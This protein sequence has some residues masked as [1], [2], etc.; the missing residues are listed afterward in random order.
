M[1]A[2]QLAGMEIEVER[3]PSHSTLED[4]VNR[5]GRGMR[6]AS[7]TGLGRSSLRAAALA[8]LRLELTPVERLRYRE[9]GR[10]VSHAVEATARNFELPATEAEVAGQ[11]VHRLY[12]RM[13]VP[14]EVYVASEERL[15]GFPRPIPGLCAGTGRMV[16]FVK[17]DGEFAEDFGHCSMVQGAA[18]YYS[19]PGV[20]S[21]EL[22]AKVERTFNRLGREDQVRRVSPGAVTGYS[23]CE[24]PLLPDGRYQLGDSVAVSWQPCVGMVPGCDTVLID[25]DG[26]EIVGDVQRWPVMHVE[27]HGHKI[28]RPDVLVR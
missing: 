13:L 7:D 12:K 5:I 6:L 27:L 15:A 18:I 2:E 17:P 11:L 21:V 3:I 9:V 24:L 25:R 23:P 26:F 10:L 22:L 1:L 20:T 19:Q 4:T 16:S 28:Q 8:R 14:L